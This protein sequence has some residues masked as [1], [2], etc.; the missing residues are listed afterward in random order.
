MRNLSRPR[1]L[2][3]PT[4]VDARLPFEPNL[5]CP[6][7]TLLIVNALEKKPTCLSKFGNRSACPGRACARGITRLAFARAGA[8]NAPIGAQRAILVSIHFVS[9]RCGVSVFGGQF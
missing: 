4:L 5:V 1:R 3:C 9:P 6:L 8:C 7:P 2:A